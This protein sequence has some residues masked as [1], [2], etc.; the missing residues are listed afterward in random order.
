MPLVLRYADFDLLFLWLGSLLLLLLEEGG[1]A[2]VPPIM[3]GNISRTLGVALT[4]VA[5][6]G[7]PSPPAPDAVDLPL[8]DLRVIGPSDW[9]RR[10]STAGAPFAA[11]PDDLELAFVLAVLNLFLPRP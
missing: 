5:L 11:P 2:V 7:P 3:A 1:G 10:L 4:D 9:A 8:A 6:T